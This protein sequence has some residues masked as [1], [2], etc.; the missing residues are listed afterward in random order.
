MRKSL[1]AKQDAF[2]KAY[3]LNGEN[4]TQAAKSA[5]YKGSDNTLRVMGQ[6][7]LL[8]PAISKAIKNHREKQ[9]KAFG[10][11]FEDCLKMSLSNFKLAQSLNQIS[12]ANGALAEINKMYGNYAAEK[13][14]I[15]FE[16]PEK[17]IIELIR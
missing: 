14:H 16:E 11:S 13:R 17:L 5:G 3:I 15:K 1:T 9:K 12:A 4:A 7:N 6:E 10:V 2:V 8:K